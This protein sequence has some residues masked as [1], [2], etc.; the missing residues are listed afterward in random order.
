MKGALEE[1]PSGAYKSKSRAAARRLQ[2]RYATA[3]QLLAWR[4]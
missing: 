3:L 2:G 4:V 1:Y